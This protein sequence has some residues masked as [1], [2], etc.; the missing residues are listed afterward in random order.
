MLF[1]YQLKRCLFIFIL[2]VRFENG[3][4]SHTR[5]RLGQ[6]IICVPSAPLEFNFKNYTYNIFE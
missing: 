6:P 3:A 2:L 1:K 5:R 4:V